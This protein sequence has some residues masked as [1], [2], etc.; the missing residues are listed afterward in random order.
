MATQADV[1]AKAQLDAT[2]INENF[3]YLDTEVKKKANSSSIGNA[4]LV[5]KKNNTSLGTF[6][7][8]ATS[9]VEVNISVPTQLSDLADAE[10]CAT[11]TY[12]DSYLNDCFSVTITPLGTSV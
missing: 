2:T 11:K 3:E 9:A 4:N 10:N 5:I 1:I 8:N 7:A 12:V 6:S